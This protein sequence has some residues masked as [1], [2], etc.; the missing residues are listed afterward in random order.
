[1]DNK[2]KSKTRL[3]AIQLVSQYL[4]NNQDIELIKD[5]FDKYYR[6]TIIDENLE[7]V[8]Y[9]VN[10]LSKLTNY[11]KTINYEVFCKEI[12][13]FIKFDRRFEKWDNINQAIILMAI[14]EIRNS[15]KEKI[16]IILNDYIEI[17]KSFVSLE[18][19]KL[20]N[21]I[22]DKLINAKN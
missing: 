9:N 22:L 13:G 15:E 16:K 2:L 20:V 17:S 5:E 12:N 1:M 19:T 10:F 8:Q 21:S 11:Y 14:S 7:K 3:V 4:V 6:N 18:E